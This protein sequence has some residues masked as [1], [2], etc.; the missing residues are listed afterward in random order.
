MAGGIEVRA[1]GRSRG[2]EA[3]LLVGDDQRERMRGLGVEGGGEG[4]ALAGAEPPARPRDVVGV[5]QVAIVERDVVEPRR[6]REQP[7][8]EAVAGARGEGERAGP[9]GGGGDLGGEARVVGA[10]RG[11]VDAADGDALVE[12][13]AGIGA[14]GRA[15]LPPR[16]AGARVEGAMA[17]GRPVGEGERRRC[18]RGC[19]RCGHGDRHAGQPED[20]GGDGVRIGDHAG[21]HH[22]VAAAGDDGVDAIGAVVLGPRLDLEGDRR[23]GQ[24]ERGLATGAPRA[25]PARAERGGQARPGVRQLERTPAERSGDLDDLA[26]RGRRLAGVDLPAAEAQPRV[27]AVGDDAHQAALDAG[28]QRGGVGRIA[29]VHRQR[30]QR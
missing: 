18:G 25:A 8:Q 1:R 12:A 17:R 13:A 26:R 14:D 15:R 30:G 28:D 29:G 3:H 7:A 19:A 27:T 9:G 2:G 11:D 6:R 16:A 20:R 23:R 5:E 4:L 21:A 24:R 22:A 10:T